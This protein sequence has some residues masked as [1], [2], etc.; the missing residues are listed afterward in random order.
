MN[1]GNVMI[2]LVVSLTPLIQFVQPEI[3]VGAWL[4]YS[5]MRLIKG[6]CFVLC[7]S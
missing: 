2:R 5:A 6:F 1:P 7:F 4:A 3:E